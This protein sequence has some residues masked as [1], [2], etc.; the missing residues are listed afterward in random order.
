MTVRLKRGFACWLIAGVVLTF[1]VPAVHIETTALR[2]TRMASALM[3]SFASAALAVADLQA[4]WQA[5]VL[6]VACQPG[7]TLDI[8]ALDCARL[9]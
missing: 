1:L 4:R 3:L 9:C 7:G 5:V 2:A 8:I 6:Q